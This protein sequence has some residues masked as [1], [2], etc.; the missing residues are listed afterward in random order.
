M[1]DIEWASGVDGLETSRGSVRAGI[2]LRSGSRSSPNGVTFWPVGIQSSREVMLT[3]RIFVHTLGRSGSDLRLLRQVHGTTVIRRSADRPT[4]D[5][6]HIPAADAHFT[7]DRGPVL[8]A[9]VADCCPVIVVSQ[10]PAVIGLAHAGWRGAAQGVVE[11]L[12]SACLDSGA[13]LQDLRAWIGPCAEGARY[14]VGADTAVHF[15]SWPQALAPHPQEPAKQL[16]NVRSVLAEQLLRGGVA[17]EHLVTSLGGTI[18]DRRYHS[19]RRSRFAAG[20][21]AA[22]VTL[23]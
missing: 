3:R 19:H 18:G 14:E 20:R 17:P 21:M 13:P 2:L 12:L 23:G 15:E 10:E 5:A 9:N 8:V 22:F 16:L 6:D 11:K 4:D 1:I 7:S